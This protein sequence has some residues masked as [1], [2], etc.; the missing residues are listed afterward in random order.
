MEEELTEFQKTKIKVQQALYELEV[1]GDSFAKE[2]AAI[3]RNYLENLE[4]KIEVF[5]VKER[6]Q[7][8][9][10]RTDEESEEK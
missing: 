5:E 4:T 10:S 3:V 8:D 6:I 2:N 1:T 7:N 9:I